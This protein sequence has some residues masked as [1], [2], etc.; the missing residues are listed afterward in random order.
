MSEL[1]ISTDGLTRRFGELV[2]VQDVNLRVA[3]GQFFGFLGP[4]GAGKSTTIKMLT[5]LLAAT[6][7]RIEILGI[8]L[9]DSALEVKRQI[10]VVPEGMALF[11]RL[12]GAEYLNFVG[13]MYGLERETAA[14]RAAELLE[15]MQLA[16]QPKKLVT[17]YSHGM[18][19]KLALAA[20]VIHGPKILFLDEPF[21]GVDA[22]ASG[23]L[24]AMLQ[25]MIS[26][27]A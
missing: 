7:G 12:T 18:Q 5:G 27:G 14:K 21:E 26:R 15:F 25:R 2:A 8:S 23:T 16:D 11:G 3:P 4:N 1:A 20:A 24:K 9:A 17:D 13:R 22:I 6:A 10:G 19:K